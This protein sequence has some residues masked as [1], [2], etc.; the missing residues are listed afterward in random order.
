MYHGAGWHAKLHVS[1]GIHVQWER[2]K[3]ECYKV[4]TP[5]WYMVPWVH[6]IPD[7]LREDPILGVQDILGQVQGHNRSESWDHLWAC[8]QPLAAWPHEEVPS[9]GPK[10]A[11]EDPAAPRASVP[12]PTSAFPHVTIPR[13]RLWDGPDHLWSLWRSP[14]SFRSLPSAQA[15]AWRTDV[16]LEV[17]IISNFPRPTVHI[18]FSRFEALPSDSATFSQIG[19]MLGLVRT[20]CRMLFLSGAFT[21]RFWE[22][23]VLLYDKGAE[24]YSPM[25]VDFPSF[26]VN[27]IVSFS[28]F[29]ITI[30]CL[31]SVTCSHIESLELRGIF[32]NCSE[33]V[34]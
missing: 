21:F 28:G 11:L 34:Q 27:Y 13:T 33:A 32:K 6:T 1:R 22:L 24:L 31:C 15:G 3:W 2:C 20:R 7:G 12:G 4:R 8:Y 19:T 29:R 26:Y 23:I 17:S 25:F 10:P 30:F 14:R 5:F 9:V 18:A 16:H